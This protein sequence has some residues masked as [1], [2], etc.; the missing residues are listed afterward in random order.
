MTYLKD[1]EKKSV[2]I[3]TFEP[4]KKVSKYFIEKPKNKKQRRQ[5][6]FIYLVGMARKTTQT[7][8]DDLLQ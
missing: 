7:K 4:R 8:A 5:I 3:S 2:E 1:R 6:C